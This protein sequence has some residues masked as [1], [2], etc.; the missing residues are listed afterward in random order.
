VT[1]G[2]LS[3]RGGET[4]ADAHADEVDAEDENV[5]RCGD[6]IARWYGSLEDII[7]ESKE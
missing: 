6:S 5:N 4:E 1:V 3:L 7:W 2:K